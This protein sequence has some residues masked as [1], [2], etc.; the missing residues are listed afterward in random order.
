MSNLAE[1]SITEAAK[2]LQAGEI[3][4]VELVRA[5]KEAIAQKD[6]SIHA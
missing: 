1:L 6:A 2:K 3:T 5:C 4:S